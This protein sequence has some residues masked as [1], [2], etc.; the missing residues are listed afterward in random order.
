[1]HWKINGS[2]RN[3]QKTGRGVKIVDKK[4]SVMRIYGRRVKHPMMNFMGS[5]FMKLKNAF[6]AEIGL[7]S[8][9]T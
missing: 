8:E 9:V 4:M 1:M 5:K 6:L 3:R 2:N 7:L